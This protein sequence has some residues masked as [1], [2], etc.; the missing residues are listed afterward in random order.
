MLHNVG[1]PDRLVYYW[2][3]DGIIPELFILLAQVGGMLVV[4][5]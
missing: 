3:K 1:G 5:L 4:T 2:A